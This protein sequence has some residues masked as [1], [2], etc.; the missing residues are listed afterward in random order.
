ME[1]LEH[2]AACKCLLSM[3][4]DTTGIPLDVQDQMAAYC[5]T[6]AYET[7]GIA[8]PMVGSLQHGTGGGWRVVKETK[9]H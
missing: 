1:R 6:C 4:P 2:C 8:I 9:T 5:K 7:L 3:N